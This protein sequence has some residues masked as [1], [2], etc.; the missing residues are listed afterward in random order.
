MRHLGSFHLNKKADCFLSFH[1]DL[2]LTT[3]QLYE[4]VTVM[5]EELTDR[6]EMSQELARVE[7]LL[8]QRRKD[9]MELIAQGQGSDVPS[10]MALFDDMSDL[11][12]TILRKQRKLA[13]DTQYI[14][15]LL[16]DI[17]EAKVAE[18]RMKEQQTQL[19]AQ[20]V[21][22]NFKRLLVKVRLLVRSCRPYY[23]LPVP[24]VSVP[25]IPL[26]PSRK[27]LCRLCLQGWQTQNV[28]SAQAA[29]LGHEPWAHTRAHTHTG[30]SGAQY[31]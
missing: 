29:A 5:E 21:A 14:S 10:Q 15:N 11:I 3:L 25:T 22:N 16:N 17:P 19:R 26:K 27:P 20:M 8:E 23:P 7:E 24:T 31:V 18:S 1:S 9:F 4:N 30:F 12:P 28:A 2:C 13:F 6:K